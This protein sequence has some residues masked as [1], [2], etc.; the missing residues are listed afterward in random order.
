MFVT[1][2]DGVEDI[3][4]NAHCLGTLYESHFSFPVY[5]FDRLLGTASGAVNDGVNADQGSR[6]G[7]WFTEVSIDN[8]CSPIAKEV[9]RSGPGPDQTPDVVA[10]VECP[11]HNLPS[12][13][14]G[15]PHH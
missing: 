3:F 8:G 12:K 1:I 11:S 6:N 13:C 7:L 5:G 14:S 2:V 4:L 9:G 10:F 15:A